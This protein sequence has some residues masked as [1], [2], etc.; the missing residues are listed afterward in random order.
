[1]KPAVLTAGA[2]VA[3]V[4]ACGGS[5]THGGGR[6]PPVSAQ[7]A[8][9]KCM[10]AHGVPSFPDPLSGPGGQGFSVNLT[11]PPGSAV[12]VNGIAFSGPVFA[13][14]E[15]TCRLLGGGSAPA[16]FSES[17]KKKLLAFAR[18]MRSHGIRWADPT[19]PSGGGIMGGGPPESG[20]G[21]PDA[22]AKADP[23]ISRAARAC[24]RRAGL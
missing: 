21:R 11:G 22:R 4:A 17:E 8:L 7:L 13:A 3:G 23:A 15:R 24:N 1:M 18:C 12:S 14:A 19:F 5:A 2:I 16:P 10:R 6:R 20:A 9:A